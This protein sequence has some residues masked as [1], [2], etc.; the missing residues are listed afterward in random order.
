MAREQRGRD[1]AEVMRERVVSHSHDRVSHVTP[2]EDSGFPR[3]M[4]HIRLKLTE[5]HGPDTGRYQH[6]A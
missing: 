3:R 6:R 4:R 1:C 5:V 2:R